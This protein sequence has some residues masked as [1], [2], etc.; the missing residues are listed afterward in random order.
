MTQGL[1][2]ENLSP[3]FL[4]RK[5]E[6]FTMSFGMSDQKGVARLI[7]VDDELFNLLPLSAMLTTLHNITSAS[8]SNGKDALSAY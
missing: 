5:F 1:E 2:E 7:L 4:D 8:Y 3:K 6:T